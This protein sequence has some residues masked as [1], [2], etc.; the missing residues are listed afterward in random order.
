MTSFQLLHANE[1]S[2]KG[3]IPL[4]MCLGKYLSTKQQVQSKFD[5]AGSTN[6]IRHYRWELEK[7]SIFVAST[8][9]GWY[10]K[11]KTDIVK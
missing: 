11:G 2:K 4:R 7:S 6:L 8:I 3:H 1:E 9:I 5:F 10:Y